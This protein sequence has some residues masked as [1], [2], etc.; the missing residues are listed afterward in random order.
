MWARRTV[1]TVEIPTPIVGPAVAIATLPDA[2]AP[3]RLTHR[4]RF[5]VRPGQV[6]TW[7]LAA[8][9]TVLAGAPW[10]LPGIAVAAT[11]LVAV[12]V[13]APRWRGRFGYQWLGSL[14]RYRARRGAPAASEAIDTVLP[15]LA[16]STCA[17]RAGNRTGVAAYGRFFSAV[18]RIDAG[19]EPAE[20]IGPLLAGYRRAELPPAAV[21]LVTWRVPVGEEQVRTSWLAVRFSPAACPAAVEARGG[22]TA[23]A[24][25]ATANCVLA[26]G[27]QLA[28][29]GVEAHVLDGAALREE[30]AAALGATPG[31]AT[32]IAEHWRGQQ[33][34]GGAQA[35]YRLPSR[36]DVADALN[37]PAPDDAA[38]TAVSL[39]LTRPDTGTEPDVSL[40]LRA[41]APAAQSRITPDTVVAA[42]DLPAYRLDGEHA[43]A[44]RRTLPL[45]L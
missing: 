42:L 8:A 12:A 1:D 34:G 23:G 33:V 37:R 9:G 28:E 39:T 32:S 7:Q 26:L 43:P 40:L 19:V 13:T 22:G 27:L 2:P 35:V 29:A 31:A 16:V 38:F 24:L 4:R 5:P 15:G 25:R 20:L 3:A 41:G 18:L 36:V 30:L 6:A 10:Q 14:A 17:D 21:Q 44:T 45:A 11:G